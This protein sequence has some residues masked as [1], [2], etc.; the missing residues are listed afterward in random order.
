M[1]RYVGIISGSKRDRLTRD[2]KTVPTT[3][4]KK[5]TPEQLLQQLET[6]EAC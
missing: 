6:E 1:N 5:P 2:N 3:S 4:E